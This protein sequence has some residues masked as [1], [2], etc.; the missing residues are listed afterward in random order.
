MQP[1]RSEP[2]FGLGQ[3]TRAFYLGCRG[4]P[5]ETLLSPGGV[6][7]L[8][9]NGV[10]KAILG[11]GTNWGQGYYDVVKEQEERV[12]AGSQGSPTDP[13]LNVPM[14]K[15]FQATGTCQ[16]PPLVG[17]SCGLT[18]SASA[19]FLR[20]SNL[21]KSAYFLTDPRTTS[22]HLRA[23]EIGVGLLSSQI[24]LEQI[25]IL[26]DRPEDYKWSS[27]ECRAWHRRLPLH[28]RTL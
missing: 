10:R 22:G 18:R 23:H 28:L 17:D 3:R 19:S 11:P 2:E 15:T 25:C 8:V 13:F 24:E 20:K 12:P 27:A 7:V 1:S 9:H 21:S 6:E 16:H 5:G 4:K 26:S 14:R